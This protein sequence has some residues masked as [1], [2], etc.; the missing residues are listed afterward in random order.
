MSIFIPEGYRSS[1]DLYDTQASISLI[2]RT[3]EDRLT[4][5]LNLK[6]VSAPLFV[7]KN[8]GLNDDLDGKAEAVRFTAP[9][10]EKECVIVHSLAKWKRMALYQYQFYEGNGL[11]TDMNAIRK[12]ENPDNLHSIYVDQ[13][14]WEKVISKEKRNLYYLYETVGLI[15]ECIL[16][17]LEVLK[18]K[19]PSIRTELKKDLQIFS[20]EEL[21][22][23]YPGLSAKEREAEIVRKYGSVF[24]TGIGHVLSDGKPHDDRAADYD[25]WDLN[26]DLLY[27]HELLDCP[28]EVSSMG[29]RVDAQSLKKQLKIRNEEYKLFYPYHQMIL[30]GELPYTIGGGI[31][32]SRLCMLMMGKAH[33]G[34]VQSSVWD[35][36]TLEYCRERNV[37]IL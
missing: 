25:D 21:V 6:R 24:I 14:D 30:S 15:H 29:I 4:R 1:L 23:M 20:S 31:G 9:N 27:Y 37:T 10:I 18:Q 3:F 17:T 26:G 19:H 5:A 11:Y 2:K 32:E 35:D 28:L 36:E 33:I 8:S 34:E 13:W 16:Q 12:D 22:R 7:L